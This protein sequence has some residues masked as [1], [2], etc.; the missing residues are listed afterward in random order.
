MRR[1]FSPTEKTPI[2][3]QVE[4]FR[5]N[6][7]PLRGGG[8]GRGF[9]PFLIMMAAVV[10][11]AA[12]AGGGVLSAQQETTLAGR[13]VNGTEGAT[14]PPGLEVFLHA[15]DRE[16]G[17]VTTQT[18]VV[19][20]D[21]AFSFPVSLAGGDKAFAV[22]VE[23]AGHRYGSQLTAPENWP[24]D[25]T[26]TV[27]ESTRDIGVVSVQQHV[28][29]LGQVEKSARVMEAVE[30]V[31]LTNESDRTLVPDLA[32]AGPGM[33]SFL[34]FSLPPGATDFDIQT[35]LVGGEI[36][37]VGTGFALTAPVEPGR[38]N[39][40]F[41]FAFPYDGTSLSYRQ[42][43]LQGADAFRVMTPARLGNIRV[44]GLTPAPSIEIDGAVFNVW[45]R[46]E[47]P[48]GQGVLLDLSNL[49][50]PSLWQRFTGRITDVGLWLAVIPATLG[51]TLAIALLYGAA[52]RPR[53]AT[54]GQDIPAAAANPMS[55][56][57]SEQRQLMLTP[58]CRRLVEQVAA[59]DHQFQQGQLPESEYQTRRAA[60]KKDLLAAAQPAP[61][62]HRE[63]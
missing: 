57:T 19:D 58:E 63:G 11:S 18:A 38:H 53:T 31:T 37:P 1:L 52:R 56:L 24:D 33:F 28:M 23:H 50:Q 6:P 45:E 36:I 44:N 25:L 60:L 40:T 51:A 49:P 59:L 20:S 34:R 21:G 9:W 32:N 55:S 3:L 43:L 13:V 35:D 29:I 7:L 5:K 10:L 8:L 4:W 47:I 12:F 15:F 17:G 27:H 54:D 61:E 14:L 46:M 62:T 26:L 16:S 48:P 2:L 30:L 41:R 39:V 22:A 42:N